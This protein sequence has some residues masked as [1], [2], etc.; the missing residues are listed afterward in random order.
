[1]FRRFSALLFAALLSFTARAAAEQFTVPYD[2]PALVCPGGGAAPPDFTDGDCAPVP[3]RAVDAQGREI[4]AR[5]AFYADPASFPATEPIGLYL[6]IK[7]SSEVWLNGVRLGANG[8]PGA[9]R[10]SEEPGRMDA[11]FYAPHDLLRDGE[12]EL[13]LRLSAHRGFLKLN[14]PFH[15]L[16]L[17]PYADPS[18]EIL[19]DYARSIVTVGVFLLGAIYFA[20]AA[21]RGPSRGAS[22]LLLVLSLLAIAQLGFE[23]SRGLFPYRYPFQDLRLVFIAASAAAFGLCLLFHTAGR[24]LT[25]RRPATLA[26][27]AAA[28]LAAVILPSGFDGK[29]VFGLMVPALLSAAIAIY[30]AVK[31]QPEARAYA[32]ALTLFAALVFFF[33]N[34]FLDT[35][36]FYAVAAL[37]VFLIAQQ[38]FLFARERRLRLDASDRAR[39]L[40]IALEQA[41]QKDAPGR[42][43]IQRS[44][45]TDFVAA[46][47]I[48]Y[49]KGAG[50]YVELA[51]ADGSKILHLA[52]LQDMEQE[53]PSTF[54]RVHRSYLVNTNH[55]RTLTREASGVGALALGNG[56]TIPV[57]RRILPNVRSALQ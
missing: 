50:D 43:K 56:E 5:V 30:A 16:G 44:G 22:V 51:L 24:F 29:A 33:P 19:R 28:T 9:D 17:G 32:V 3:L 21:L 52:K 37:I 45:K 57:S 25:R 23:T 18:R 39:R 54:L 53:L 20:V 26:L 55:V 12:N 11:V 31:K 42:L 2:S 38:A 34:A 40:E 4:W 41:R 8:L 36:F 6:S 10:A 1:M 15:W 35:G 7:A 48:V 14:Y 13:A 47:E 46:N 27:G 49:C